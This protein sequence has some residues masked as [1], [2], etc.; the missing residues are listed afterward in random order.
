MEAQDTTSITKEKILQA[1][2]GNESGLTESD[3][4]EAISARRANLIRILFEQGIIT[5]TGCGKRGDPYKYRVNKERDCSENSSPTQ[6]Q[7]SPQNELDINT[8]SEAELSS[9]FE[10][11][12]LLNVQ[13]D[14]LQVLGQLKDKEILSL[15]D[16]QNILQEKETV[17]TENQFSPKQNSD[18]ERHDEGLEK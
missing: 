15:E 13:F 12:R 2:S 10:V 9:V 11:F 14:H 16:Y 5:R 17:R 1:L 18:K 8:F 6:N 7:I 3:L 4:V